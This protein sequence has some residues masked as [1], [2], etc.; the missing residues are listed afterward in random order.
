LHLAC[1][2]KWEKMYT[3]F[4]L[5]NVKKGRSQLGNLDVNGRPI[6]KR[7]LTKYG[8][9]AWRGVTGSCERCNKPTG[10]I[11]EENLLTRSVTVSFSTAPRSW[12]CSSGAR[13]NCDVKF[14]CAV[15]GWCDGGRAGGRAGGPLTPQLPVDTMRRAGPGRAGVPWRWAPA[16]T[17]QRLRQTGGRNFTA[18]Y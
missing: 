2:R 6:L 5:E 10:S 7:T 8:V 3:K 16:D 15:R 9:R 14:S 4:W 11:K 12:L 18:V 13:T 17:G 1:S